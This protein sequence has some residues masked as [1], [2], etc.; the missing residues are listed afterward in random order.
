MGIALPQVHAALVGRRH[1]SHLLVLPPTLR[2][3]GFRHK[4]Q[5][6][7]RQ[8]RRQEDL[9]IERSKQ[10]V[11]EVVAGEHGRCILPE[12]VVPDV[13][14]G[15]RRRDRDTPGLC[16]GDSCIVVDHLCFLSPVLGRGSFEP[17]GATPVTHHEFHCL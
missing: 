7:Y 8:V 11:F 13:G 9:A 14:I 15:V 4:P 6:A 3:V 1:A 12:P 17:P 5:T 16:R 2:V 10:H